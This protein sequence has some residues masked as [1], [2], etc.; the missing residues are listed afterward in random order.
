[1]NHQKKDWLKEDPV[2]DSQKIALVSMMEPKNHL[3]VRNR[4]SFFATH[5]ITW[6]LQEHNNTKE[7]M[8]KFPDQPL[9]DLMKEKL[10]FSYQNIQKQYYSYIENDENGLSDIFNRENNKNNEP[11]ITG[12]K[13]RGTYE[14]LEQAKYDARKFHDLEPA[15]DIYTVPV[16]KWMPYIPENSAG[17]TAEYT[18]K[19]LQSLME[20]K[21]IEMDIRKADFDD[22]FL[23]K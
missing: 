22:R 4:E 5:F 11:I 3:L 16:G 20:Q 12:F 6:F 23:K 8:K 10:D 7:F 18:E 14:T 21:N 15:V 1:M 17:V 13:I 19:K 2:I 9:S